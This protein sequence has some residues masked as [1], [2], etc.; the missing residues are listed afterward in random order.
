MSKTIW[1][2]DICLAEAKKYTSR[3]DFEKNCLGAYQACWRNKWIDKVCGHMLTRSQAVSRG[4]TIWTI[5]LCHEQA[6]R[7][8][9][10]KEFELG[11]KN[12]YKA[13]VRNK[14]IDQIC[15]HMPQYAM[16]DATKHEVNSVH[17]PMIE[18]VSKLGFIV[19]KEYKLSKCSRI[20][21]KLSHPKLK[22]NILIEL[23]RSDMLNMDKSQISRYKK[24]SKQKRHNCS[25]LFFV[26]PQGKHKKHGFISFEQLETELKGLI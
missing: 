11:S 21:L 12:A 2:Y 3:H 10:K 4:Q 13:A 24:L 1:T 5:N 9:T 19:H 8:K 16:V 20:D 15:T 22:K 23:K 14:W 6:L 17:K 7:Y 25:H 18:I 26:D